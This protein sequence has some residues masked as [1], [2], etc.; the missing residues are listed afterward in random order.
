MIIFVQYP[1]YISD[2]VYTAPELLRLQRVNRPTYGTKTGDIYAFAIII[3][4]AILMD[5]PYALDL[6]DMSLKGKLSYD[7]S[8]SDFK[9]TLSC[10]LSILS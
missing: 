5:K 1:T 8:N 2:L 7:Y 4:E 10:F 6:Q 3:Q 9:N